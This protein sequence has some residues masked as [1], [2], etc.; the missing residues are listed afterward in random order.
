MGRITILF[1]GQSSER[2]VSVA[3][4]Q[5]LAKNIET[6]MLWF[7]SPDGSVILVDQDELVS[8]DRPFEDA[9]TPKRHPFAAHLAD[10]LDIAREKRLT[11][12]FGLH[13]TGVEDGKLAR[14]CEIR[15]VPFTGSGSHAS[16]IAFDKFTSKEKARAAGIQVAPSLVIREAR[17]VTSIAAWLDLHGQLVAKPIADG[18]SSGLMFIARGE[19]LD[20][21]QNALQSAPHLVEPRLSGLEVT[22][23]VHEYDGR[24]EALPVVEI[25]VQAGFV[26]DYRGKYLGQGTEEICPA[27]IERSVEQSLQHHATEIHKAVGAFGYSRSDFIVTADGPTFLEINTLPGLTSAS[28]FPLA[29]QVAGISFQ[30]FIGHQIKIAEDRSARP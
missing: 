16:E 8:H 3:T 2:L 19:P 9:F 20:T 22:V 28:L 27:R 18:S 5:N 4:A 6:A 7:W 10:A 23:G 29:L 14:E 21:L 13:G 12:V 24:I 26:F 15:G 25:A 30:D 11:L 1:G 17:D